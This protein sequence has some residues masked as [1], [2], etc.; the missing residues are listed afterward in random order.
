MSYSF[1][2]KPVDENATIV[3]LDYEIPDSGLCSKAFVW[4]VLLVEN[5]EP[6]SLSQT[7]FE[8]CIM[9]NKLVQFT[10]D[11]TWVKNYDLIWTMPKTHPRFVTDRILSLVCVYLN[12]IYFSQMTSMIAVKWT[13][14]QRDSKRQFRSNQCDLSSIFLE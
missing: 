12:R 14:V 8:W 11:K 9:F 5:W 4:L 13:T 10:S 1:P 2:V 3:S 7:Y 6:P